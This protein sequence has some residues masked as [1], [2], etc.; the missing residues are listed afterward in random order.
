V[1]NYL[2]KIFLG[3]FFSIFIISNISAQRLTI[4]ELFEAGE[5]QQLIELITQNQETNQLPLEQLEVLAYSYTALGNYTEAEK[6]YEKLVERENPQAKY[7]LYYADVLFANRRL[8][9]SKQQYKAYLTKKPEDAYAKLKIQSCDSLLLWQDNET[10][11]IVKAF[12]EAQAE[13]DESGNVFKKAKFLFLPQRNGISFR[14][15]SMQ[16]LVKK[17][18][19]SDDYWCS[20]VAYN[21]TD[22]ILAYSVRKREETRRGI[23]YGNSKIMF[24]KPNNPDADKLET[25]SW[26]GM[27]E[28]INIAH[29][30]FS[31]N[32]SRLYFASDMPGGKGGTD[33]YYSDYVNGA[34]SV[35]VNIG[36]PI[37]TSFNELS[38][39]KVGDTL[40]YASDG[41]PGYGRLDIF[42]SLV[43]ED[44][45][46]RPV[47]I[48]APINSLGNELLYRPYSDEKALLS[49]D[50]A[51]PEEA[52]LDVYSVITI[53]K[54]QPKDTLDEPAVEPSLDMEA[55]QLPYLFFAV[56]ESEVQPDY[57]PVLKNLA[58]TLRK[59]DDIRLEIL[60]Y[61]DINGKKAYNRELSR[62]RAKAIYDTLINCGAP[63][64]QMSFNALGESNDSTLSNLSYHVFIGTALSADETAWYEK[65]LN[66]DYKVHVTKNGNFYSYYIGEYDKPADA[67]TRA[68]QLEE[69]YKLQ[70]V[71]GASY[72][73]KFLPDYLKA[74]NR[75]AE[76]ELSEED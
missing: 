72:R 58:D 24:D 19:L 15:D 2:Y 8:E 45:Y 28:N 4:N 69:N 1:K 67:K 56:D 64:K 63:A 57:M 60:A 22:Q 46:S 59:Y 51:A 14:K 62:E 43:D 76:L 23:H 42:Y 55:Y 17:P 26:E 20:S 53:H 68:E 25:F 71:V 48:K 6:V 31:Q 5:Y 18:W 12:S 44:E 36:S 37:N 9:K 52:V 33:L 40:F 10:D 35:P 21:E 54:E 16:M 39:A 66:N 27:P 50:R 70:T 34:W 41:H 32:G 47:N 7:Y 13:D 3:L 65:K 73:G 29:P 38:P 61:A 75:R 11:K 49:S 74:V 30:S